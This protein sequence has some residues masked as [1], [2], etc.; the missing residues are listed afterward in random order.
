MTLVDEPPIRADPRFLLAN[1]RTLLAWVRTAL[2]LLAAGG[3]IYEFSDVSGRKA[4]AIAVALV[5]I[6]S[7]GAGGLRYVATARAIRNGEQMTDDRSPAVLAVAVCL[8]GIG[9][10]IALLVS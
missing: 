7:T 8:L 2:A 6:F 4:L 3:G 9:L 10:L 5:G 1:E